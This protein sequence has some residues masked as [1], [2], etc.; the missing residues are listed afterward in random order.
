MRKTLL[1]ATLATT[2]TAFSAQASSV[3]GLEIGLGYGA[4]AGPTL[5][6]SYPLTETL[7]IRGALSSG[8][9]VSETS[10][11]TDIEYDVES[12]GGINRIAL[13]Y[14]PFENGFFVSAGYAVNNFELNIDGSGS[15]TVEVGTVT[16]D[17]ADI[18]IDGNI[19]WKN[20]PSL[21]IGWGHTPSKGFGYMVELG[22][23]FT[24]AGDANLDGTC[25][26]NDPLLTEC[27]GFE[28]SLK[29]EEKELQEDVADYEIL[30]VLQAGVTYR[31]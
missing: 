7:Q 28:E 9:G 20:S 12:S 22:A 8:M 11:D 31:F 10:S 18:T 5:E 6:L 21:S 15:G 13:D 26:P 4:F 3:E 24:G 16:Y 1:T 17:A 30:P 14:H 23:Y 19:S 2:F 29:E 27:P 25:T